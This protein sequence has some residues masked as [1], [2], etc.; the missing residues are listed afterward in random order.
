MKVS[1]IITALEKVKTEHGDLECFTYH[2]KI[3]E[4]SCVACHDGVERDPVAPPNN[5]I[6]IEFIEG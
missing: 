6:V 4:V 3:L 2:G 1:D 5:E